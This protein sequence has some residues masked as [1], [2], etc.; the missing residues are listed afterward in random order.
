MRLLRLLGPRERDFCGCDATSCCH[1]G[2][3]FR[4]AR[5]VAGAL[6]SLPLRRGCGA[7]AI[8]RVALQ[9]TDNGCDSWDS[10]NETSTKAL[11]RR[12]GP[13]VGAARWVVRNAAALCGL[14]TWPTGLPVPG[15]AGF[16]LK[17]IVK[18]PQRSV[19]WFDVQGCRW[20]WRC[21]HVR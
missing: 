9:T 7:S 1:A 16:I 21:G 15:H 11:S 13:R 2:A 20:L 17:P 10:F 18:C 3:A 8:G 6:L 12:I 14:P 19:R 5:Q 4:A